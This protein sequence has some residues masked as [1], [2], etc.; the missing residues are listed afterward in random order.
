MVHAF[1]RKVIAT[2]FKHARAPFIMGNFS[3]YVPFPCCPASRN[4]TLDSEQESPIYGRQ[5]LAFDEI[6]RLMK[7]PES[8]SL[9]FFQC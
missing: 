4:G 2:G 8:P 6:S 9:P 7:K 1:L 5:L 3:G